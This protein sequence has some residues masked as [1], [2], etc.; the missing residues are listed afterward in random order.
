MSDTNKPGRGAVPPPSEPAIL[1]SA[2]GKKAGTITPAIPLAPP[3]A[4]ATRD[5]EGSPPSP[6]SLPAEAKGALQP[7][8]AD[9]SPPLDV[10]AVM[11][12]GS[13]RTMSP[14]AAMES[15]VGPLLKPQ[16]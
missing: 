7:D 13:I 8:F 2:R 3:V 1:P 11:N 14:P 15:V 6:G 5:L 12:I 9:P 10:G 16:R 4:G